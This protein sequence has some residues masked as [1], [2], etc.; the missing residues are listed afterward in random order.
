RF[1]D[2]LEAFGIG[3]ATGL[4]I[5]GE[6]SGIVI[7]ENTVKRVDLARIG[8]GQSV[9]VTPVQLLT[10][11]CS[12]VNG[13]KLLRPYVVRQITD[14]NG[15][16]LEQGET[17][18]VARPISEET[19]TVMRRLLEAVVEDGGGRN[20]AV[21]G[22]AIGGKTGTAQV[23]VDGAVSTD[24]HIGSFLGFAPADDPVFAVLVIVDEADV[25]VD[26]GSQTAAPFARDIFEKT[27]PYLGIAPQLEEEAP[28]ETEVPDVIGMDP[29]SARNTM[30][31]RGLRCVMDG[32][33]GRII[34]QLPAAGARIAEGSLVMLYVDK[35]VGLEDNSRIR[36]PDVTGMSVLEANKLL[37][38]YGLVMQV[39]GGGIATSQSPEADAEVY[40]TT[41]VTVTF[42]A[43]DP[44]G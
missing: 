37:M 40:P 4:D 36:V 43:P 8:F 12:V 24:T 38:S 23:Y 22:Y 14:G 1:Y 32:S 18:V 15:T 13:G 17:Q 26:F 9:A 42:T 35:A 10:A 16:I 21:S 44:S 25:A 31:Q 5:P 39:E 28:V 41:V 6:S 20:A 34:N 3:R 30:E 7:P 2:Y 29:D 11:A 19:S 27:L 33:G